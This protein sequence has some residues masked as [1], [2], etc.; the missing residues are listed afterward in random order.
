MHAFEWCTFTNVIFTSVINMLEG[1]WQGCGCRRWPVQGGSRCGMWQF[2][3]M[4]PHVFLKGT[5]V[6]EGIMACQQLL[7]EEA[8]EAF[9]GEVTRDGGVVASTMGRVVFGFGVSGLAT[10]PALFVG[11]GAQTCIYVVGE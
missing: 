1:Q 8:V 9:C 3:G 5:F 4:S 11:A 10:Y 7:V 6:A 2:E